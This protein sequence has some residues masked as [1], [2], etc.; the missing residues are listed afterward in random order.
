MSNNP[1]IS[2]VVPVYNT[3]EYLPKCLD[4]LLAQ[5]YSN[6]E[7]IC[8]DDG[9]SDNSLEILNEYAK[10]DDRIVVLSQENSG[11]SVARNKGINAATGE[12]ISFI[13]SDDW[14]YLNL[15]QSFVDSINKSDKTVDIWMF[16]V[17]SYV[18]GKNDILPFVFFESSD[19]NN[20]DSEDS[21]H[22]FEDC[23]RPF[24]RNLS[25]ANKIYRKAFLDDIGL[26]FEEGLKYEDQCFCIKAFLNANVIKFSDDV[27]Y[28]YRNYH[29]TSVSATVSEKAFD[30]FDIVDL[31]EEEIMKLGVYESY[32]YAL[33]QY[34]YNVYSQHFTLCPRNLKQQ[35]FEVMKGKLL[36]AEIQGL[37][38]LISRRLSNYLMF[39]Q[40][41]NLNFQEY[42]AFMEQ[43]VAKTKA[44]Q[45]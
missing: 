12:Y 20:H 42:D 19:W 3:G 44:A 41:K 5:M 40:I 38:P 2:V 9:S 36:A 21:I 7:I 37:D 26:R 14:V 24:S 8:V 18:E 15:Y 45:V 22:T 6:L 23:K 29:H 1:K 28:R 34:K 39:V 31:I 43:L 16:N 10:K 33:F 13:D 30:I 11:A 25:A 32:K 27:F 17:S 4:T 35:Y